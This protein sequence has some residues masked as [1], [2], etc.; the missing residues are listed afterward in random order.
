M[1]GLRNRSVW[2]TITEVF[3]VLR[4]QLLALLNAL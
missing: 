1:Y 3:P 4:E 2:T